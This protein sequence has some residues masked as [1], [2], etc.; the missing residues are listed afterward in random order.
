M[1][2]NRLPRWLLWAL[3]LSLCANLFLVGAIVGYRTG[4]VGGPRP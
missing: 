4:N 3:A 1:S 2:S